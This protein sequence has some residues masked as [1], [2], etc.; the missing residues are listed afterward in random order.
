MFYCATRKFLTSRL[1]SAEVAP[2]L[3]PPS[4]RTV[5]RDFSRSYDFAQKSPKTE[6]RFGVSSKGTGLLR[7]PRRKMV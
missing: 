7:G 2:P 1:T 3:G 6:M 5:Q 4:T